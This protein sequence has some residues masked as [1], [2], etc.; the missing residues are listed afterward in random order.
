MCNIQIFF[1]GFACANSKMSH[2]PVPGTV[3]RPQSRCGETLSCSR[4]DKKGKKVSP[5]PMMPIELN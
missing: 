1:T 2:I 3:Q 5:C 4:G